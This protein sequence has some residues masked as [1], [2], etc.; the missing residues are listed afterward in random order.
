LKQYL[1]STYF[2]D[3]ENDVVRD[4]A[5]GITEGV[6]D[7]RLKAVLLFEAVRDGLWYDPYSVTIEREAFRA[8][9]I[10]QGRTAY[11]VPKAIAL[12]AAGRAVGLPTRLGFADIRNYLAPPRLLEQLG[13]DVFVFHGLTEIHLGERW[14]K[15]TPAF[16]AGLCRRFGIATVKF[17]GVADALFQP[18]DLE[19]RRHI[20]YIRDRGTFADLPFEDMVGVYGETYPSVGS[21]G[22]AFK[23]RQTPGN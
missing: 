14:V 7:P 15:A 4:F 5:L 12:A 19:G 20:E 21:D 2:I 16:N 9:V 22:L 1:A 3:H 6:E 23:E 10:L 11:C 18:F 13:T 8:S 17:D